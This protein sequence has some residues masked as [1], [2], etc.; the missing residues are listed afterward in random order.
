MEI[1]LLSFGYKHGIPD[2]I[3]L[4]FDL[5]F[6]PNPYYIPE[7]SSKNGQNQQVAAYAINNQAGDDFLAL[8]KPLIEF[9]INQYRHKNKKKIVITIGCT[10]GRHRSVA[11]VEALAKKLVQTV[12][13]THRDIYKE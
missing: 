11:M 4:L 3:N 2:S 1:I 5:R 8:S 7:L 9:T 6:L 10:G 12:T 13:V